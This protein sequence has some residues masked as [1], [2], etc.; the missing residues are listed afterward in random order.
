ML[1]Y[2]GKASCSVSCPFPAL[3]GHTPLLLGWPSSLGLN[4][5]GHGDRASHAGQQVDYTGM[6]GFTLYSLL[7]R[8]HGFR[9]SVEPTVTP[10][11]HHPNRSL[12]RMGWPLARSSVGRSLPRGRDR[13]ATAP[14]TNPP[15]SPPPAYPSSLQVLCGDHGLVVELLTAE[16]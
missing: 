8:E 7:M 13:A 10:T 14:P 15:V 11:D 16:R 2:V 6:M 12:Q 9:P 4:H 1:P 3:G 5:K